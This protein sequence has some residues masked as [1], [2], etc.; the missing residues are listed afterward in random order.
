MRFRG[1]N[2]VV[3]ACALA[4]TANAEERDTQ[5]AAEIA[6]EAVA[7]YRAGNYEK[8][9]S[10]FV[11]A[12]DLSGRATQLRNAAKA[13]EAGGLLDQAIGLWKR[14]R[15]HEGVEVDEQSE[16]TAHI[17]LIEERK[18]SRAALEQVE[19]AQAE[20]EKAKAEAV[21]AK[22]EAAAAR[23]QIGRE[24]PAPA[25]RGG[26]SD[27]LGYIGIG[28]GGAIVAAGAVL[29]FVQSSRLASLDERL[30]QRDPSGKIIDITP[31]EVQSEVN[32]INNQRLASGVLL[33]VG[34]AVAAAGVGWLMFAPDDDAPVATVESVGATLAITPEGAAVM[35]VVTW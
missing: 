4:S 30:A 23:A 33:G 25:R 31:G 22:R 11:E 24:S 18:R 28:S 19:Q 3:V 16:A 7:L 32:A 6:A 15:D 9:G 13:Y 35:G 20:T 34:V 2:V 29:W 1:F 26:S 21:K 10:L 27:Y 14:Y 8:A 17:N 12:Y 5:L